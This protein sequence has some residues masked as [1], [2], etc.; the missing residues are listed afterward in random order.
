MNYMDKI[1][2]KP[3][4]AIHCLVYNH[5]P[6]LRDCFEGFVM[7][8]TNFPFV[9]IV[10]D[11]A[12]TDG[13]AAVIR[14]YEQKYPHIFKPIFET[15]NQWSKRDGTLESIMNNAIDASGAKYVAMCEGDDYWLDPLKLQ[16]QVDI[17]EA[18]ITL[19]TVVTDTKIVDNHS[20]IINAKRGGV[21]NGDIEGRYSLR[22]FFKYNHQ[23]PTAS[24]MYRNVHQ[25]EVREK[26]RQTVNPYLGDWTMWICLHIYGDFY[27]LN[28]ASVAYRINPTS[29][30]H[31]CNRVGRA[32]AHRDICKAVAEILPNEYADIR[33]ALR[34]LDWVWLELLLAYKFERKYM[35]VFGCLMMV[36]IKCP[37]L[38]WKTY[39]KS[40]YNR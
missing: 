23:Y 26:Y 19:M 39:K 28:E 40:K 29:V 8:Q 30:T 31:T 17:L 38:L 9:A 22:D 36:L 13:S 34:N 10:H 12:S 14:E 24:V 5:E 33:D 27:Y 2:Y 4:V 16:K 15:E 11:D 32:K 3:L 6:Y 21:V 18:D 35:R 25:Q 20:N 1:D 37:K 7:Q